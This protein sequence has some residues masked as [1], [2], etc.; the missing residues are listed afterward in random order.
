MTDLS[1]IRK[2][3]EYIFFPICL[4]LNQQLTEIMYVSLLYTDLRDIEM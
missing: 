1:I 2:Y 3:S 4:F